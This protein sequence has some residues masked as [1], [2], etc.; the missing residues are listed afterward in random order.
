MEKIRIK[1]FEFGIV[2]G[3]KTG[4]TGE[5]PDKGF[6][7]GNIGFESRNIYLLVILPISVT[8][9]D[10]PC[11]VFAEEVWDE[12]NSYDC[13]EMNNFPYINLFDDDVEGLMSCFEE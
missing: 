3:W 5:L 4:L 8:K 6:E 10:V 9:G 7:S 11:M 1:T 13:I 12:T 2:E